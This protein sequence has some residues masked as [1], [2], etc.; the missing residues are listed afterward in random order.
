MKEFGES[1]YEAT[2]AELDNN[3]IGMGAIK[4]LERLEV[5]TVVYKNALSYLMFCK[6]KM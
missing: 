3:L 1:G 4:M 6:R 5:T 2:L